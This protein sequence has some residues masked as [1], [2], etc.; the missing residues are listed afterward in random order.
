MFL[1]NE[2]QV[3]LVDKKHSIDFLE[4]LISD[5]NQ[6]HSKFMWCGLHTPTNNVRYYKV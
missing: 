1:E 3:Y 6:L 4:C 5:I 2:D